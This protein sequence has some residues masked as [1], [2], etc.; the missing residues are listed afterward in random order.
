MGT[1]QRL[2]CPL[3]VS[4]ASACVA[5]AADPGSAALA[6]A[7]PACPPPTTLELG[8]CVLSTDVIVDHTIE[9]TDDMVLDCHDHEVI[10]AN[11]G[12]V[13]DP[14]TS[15]NEFEPSRPEVAFLVHGA[16]GV[17]L[18]NCP[19][20]GFDF[21]IVAAGITDPPH[22]NQFLDNTLAVRTTAVL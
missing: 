15:A 11:P 1:A 9:L 14:A 4:L 20:R 10:S 16:S 3:S 13:D 6:L 2:L 21:G 22:P 8:D 7:W 19:A 17:I 5:P 18:R 12:V